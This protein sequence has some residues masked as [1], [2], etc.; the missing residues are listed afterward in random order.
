MADMANKVT[1]KVR[2]TAKVEADRVKAEA[3]Q[4]VQSGAYIYPLRGIIFFLTNSTLWKPL[5]KNLA[6]TI[7]LGIGITTFMFFF[8]YLPQVAILTLFNGP[9]AVFTTVLLVLSESST[10]TTVLSR[11][12]FIDDALVDTF[13][14]TLL[15]RN[16]HTLVSSGR[17]LEGGRNSSDPMAALGKI[18]K[19]PFIKF[20]PQSIIRYFMYLPLNF[21]PVVGTAL[22]VILQG[23]KLGPL[24]HARYFQLKGMTEKQRDKWVDERT[25]EYT[26][27]G[28][29]AVLLELI[30][31][32][33]IFF[34]FTNTVGA[35]LWAADLEQKGG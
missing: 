23:K 22:F 9:L 8:T 21:I 10:L 15:V 1:E 32:A 18:M 7:T 33:S 2:E 25:G 29:P 17:E 12:F 30:P 3:Q 6:P 31:V 16:M 11:S 5:M 4:A 35:A 19:R 14:G 13:D 27:F 26:S 24:S 34:A 20:T 28:I